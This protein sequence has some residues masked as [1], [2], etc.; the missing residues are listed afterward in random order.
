MFKINKNSY[1]ITKV[2]KSIHLSKLI[3]VPLILGLS[4][5]NVFAGDNIILDV[6][7]APV[8]G[9]GLVGGAP[10]EFNVLFR[11]SDPTVANSQYLDPA[12]PGQFI[13][14]GGY[15]EIELGGSYKRN[16]DYIDART[17]GN[18]IA[19]NRNIIL[20]TAP[21]GP[22]VATAG[23]GVQHGNWR[24]SDDGARTMTITPNGINAN[25][26][27]GLENARAANGFKVVH[28]RPDPR[29]TR[30]DLSRAPFINGP[31]GSF[32]RIYIR[33][34]DAN[35]MIDQYGHKEV[36]FTRANGP[37]I[38]IT[39][40]GVT[41]S[42]QGNSATVSTE[43]DESVHYQH[44]PVNTE[45][46]NTL[47]STPFSAGTPYALRFLLFA[48][49]ASQPDPFI[50]QKGLPAV[51]YFINAQHPNKAT[52]VQDTN[53][54]GVA[55]EHDLELGEIKISGPD[56]NAAILAN[57]NLTTSGDGI[58]GANGSLLIVPVKVG[59]LAGEYKI[60]LSMDNGNEIKTYVIAE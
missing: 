57:P 9:N 32:G 5:L 21:Q 7:S 2:S 27:T 34:F 43:I 37:Q 15:L 46:T 10:T 24:V 36:Q 56:K 26:I 48:G 42:R 59:T 6:V 13:P 17:G 29:D 33:I 23:A 38:S 16:P 35:G 58:T 44:V 12:N 55:D 22:I 19:P 25:N 53:N 49:S 20:T 51:G 52:L 8:V 50:P 28:V 11:S 54:N 40:V 47:K 60:Q 18:S 31:A 14:V 45:L 1:K 39:N 4:S 41:T 3:A 30:T